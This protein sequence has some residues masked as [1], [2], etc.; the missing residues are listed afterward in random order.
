MAKKTL[1]RDVIELSR[2]LGEDPSFADGL[3]D[4][5]DRRKIVRAL[6]VAR[7]VMGLTQG[8]VAERL[9]CSRGRIARVETSEDSDLN[10]GLIVRYARAVGLR[11]DVSLVGDAAA[12]PGR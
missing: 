3:A 9:G 7:A 2:H 10:L 11:L 8:E 6:T 5:L 12:S 4:Y 1:Y